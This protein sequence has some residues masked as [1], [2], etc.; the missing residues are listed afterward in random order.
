M[1]TLEVSAGGGGEH[2]TLALSVKTM[3]YLA[4]HG[5]HLPTKWPIIDVLRRIASSPGVGAW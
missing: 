4:G 3:P 5:G 1:F 2:R